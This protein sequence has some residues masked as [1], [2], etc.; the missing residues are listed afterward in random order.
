MEYNKENFEKEIKQL[1]EEFELRKRKIISLY[2]SEN[3]PHKLGDIIADGF[4]T[5]LI[6]KIQFRLGYS[7][8]F[9]Q[10]VYYGFV[11]KKDKTPRKD[12]SRDSIYQCNIK[13][14]KDE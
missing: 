13:T 8:N 3:N 7:S 9:P 5:I 4:R 12:K 10:C 14:L 11:L 6:D 2:A 1:E